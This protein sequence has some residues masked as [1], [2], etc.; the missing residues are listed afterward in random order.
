MKSM[1]SM[2]IRIYNALKLAEQYHG[3]QKYGDH[4]YMYHIHECIDTAIA[5]GYNDDDLLISLALHDTIED[6]TLSQEM[7][8]N[9]FSEKIALTVWAVSGI[10]NNRKERMKSIYQKIG[11][12]DISGLVKLIDRYCNYKN[13]TDG[14]SHRKMYDKEMDEFIENLS[15][16]TKTEDMDR[17]IK[18]YK[19]RIK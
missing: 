10:G 18:L 5:W 19:N 7:I 1:K 2:N 9:E 4:S 8:A 11:L 16:Y 3:D 14:S 6:T 17:L 13:T 15:K 12:T